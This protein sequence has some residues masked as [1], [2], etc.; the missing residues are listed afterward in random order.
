MQHRVKFLSLFFA[1]GSLQ[2]VQCVD[3]ESVTEVAPEE[4]SIE[5]DVEFRGL[6]PAGSYCNT[7]CQCELGTECKPNSQGQKVCTMI[8][9]TA[10]PPPAPQCA[11]SCQCPYGKSCYF[12]DKFSQYGECKSNK[13]TCTNSCD[14]GIHGTCVNGTCELAFGPYPQCT[15]SKHCPFNAACIDG[16]CKK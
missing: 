7:S 13:G 6:K 10:P 5:E 3:G 8:P 16:I 12:T 4:G 11:F 14:C 1:L 9:L 15:C 2:F